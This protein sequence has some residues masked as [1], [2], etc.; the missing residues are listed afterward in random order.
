M[1]SISSADRSTASEVACL[2][3]HA[4]NP[5]QAKFCMACGMGLQR[6]CPR[7]HFRNQSQAR[8]CIECGKSL[9]SSPIRSNGKPRPA[10]R[11][12]LTV[13]FCDL[14]GSTALSEQLD[15]EEL[16]ELVQT[17]QETCATV[18]LKFEGYIAQYL[19]DG[20]LIYFGYPVAHENDA[21]RSV[22]AALGIIEAIQSLK[23]GCAA[24]Q[25]L[26]LSVRLGIHTGLVVVGE[27]GAG[28]KREQ[29]AI[30]QTPNVAARLQGLAEPNTAV[31]SPTT[32]RMVRGIFEFES[33]GQHSLKGVSQSVELHQVLQ[34]AGYCKRMKVAASQWTPYVGRTAELEQ[35]ETLWQQA[36]SGQGQAVLMVGEAGIGK[37]RLIQ[38]FRQ[39]IAADVYTL[40]EVYCSPYHRN[41]PF[42]PII[43]MLRERVIRLDRGNTP[44]QN[45]DQ[46]EQFLS[47]HQIDRQATVPMFAQLLS[48][49][50]NDRYSPPNL[51]PQA[52]KQKLLQFI[53]TLIQQH[54]RQQPLLVIVED[55]QWV[56][57]STLELIERLLEDET[58]Y[59]ILRIYTTRPSF[60]VD[61][62][63]VPNLTQITL[64]RLTPD[65]VEQIIHGI[66]RGKRLPSAVQ[67]LL[68]DKSDGVPLFVEEIT[69][70]V[71]ESGWLQETEDTY[72]PAGHLPLNLMIPDTLKGLLMERLDRLEAAK[73]VA[74]LGATIG[75]E[76]SYELLRA[77]T[78]TTQQNLSKQNLAGSSRSIQPNDGLLDEETI[79]QGLERLVETQLLLANGE[80]PMASYIF[81]NVLIQDAAYDSLL[82]ST[83]QQYHRRIAIVLEGEFPDIVA[84]EPELLAYHYDRA[85]LPQ[86]AIP[87]W[88]QAGQL[89]FDKSANQEAIAH[90]KAGLVSVQALEETPEKLHAELELQTLLGKALI[91]INGYAAP[92]VAQVYCRSQELCRQLPQNLDNA[93]QLFTILW[94]LFAYHVARSDHRAAL[95]FAS[96]LMGLARRCN[97]PMMEMEAH[98]TVG[99]SLHFMGQL[100]AAQEHWLEGACLHENLSLPCRT[101][102]TGQD[103]GI[104]TY[105]FLAWNSWFL[106][107]P[108]TALRYAEMAVDLAQQRA[109]PY[110]TSLA[111]TMKAI[112]HQVQGDLAQLQID[113]ERAITMTQEQHFKF[114]LAEGKIMAGWVELEQG[115]LEAGIAQLRQG[116][117]DH[118]A[119]GARIS[120][121]QFL[122]LLAQAHAKLGQF[123][124][125]LAVLEEALNMVQEREER[126]WEAE[127]YRLQG[128]LSQKSIQ[129]LGAGTVSTQVQPEVC[130]R[131]ALKIA[132][133]QGAKSLELRITISLARFLNRQGR[134]ES[135]RSMLGSIFHQFSEG[136]ETTDL[137]EANQ[138]FEE[139]QRF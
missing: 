124:A 51:S 80:M 55:L 103:V 109:H 93:P 133:E 112:F 38:A 37:S 16:R 14:V 130:F 42:H 61:W 66:T 64:D 31:L 102:F 106:G 105:S 12:Q 129:R 128:E 71:V 36:K 97:D 88:Q 96:Q 78:S 8:F 77:V 101:C 5:P 120:Q 94:G 131:R 72:E 113:V 26:K 98:F 32:Y 67:K 92:Q 6:I 84:R 56:D 83:R 85:R 39:A 30:G 86:Q 110:S 45:L 121:T 127:L 3:C 57:P 65:H 138:L 74:Q 116:I 11:R 44:E 21:E 50:L 53:L 19:G 87:Y 34:E 123:E 28:N 89:A 90:L 46:L 23:F 43:E 104:S 75:R 22:R 76:F 82:R 13:M 107:Q 60:M 122:G 111:M 134:T 136:F 137:M 4:L 125:G 18:V 95:N 40:R 58:Q 59:P 48:I 41:T 10:E 29:L 27:V 68:V 15:P 20:I 81:R 49:P 99:L 9:L 126:F 69:K 91:A 54:S 108:E 2:H 119:T 62:S 117:A 79:V 52:Q 35:L 1:S 135:A 118:Q 115:N 33:L 17:Y 63:T 47:Q 7:C 24:Q 139:L 100:K 73:E 25:C 132:Q 70:M 114:W